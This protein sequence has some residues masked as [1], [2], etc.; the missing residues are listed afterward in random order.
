MCFDTPYNVLDYPWDHQITKQEL[1][2]ILSQFGVSQRTHNN[3]CVVVMYHKPR[4]TDIVMSAME[5]CQY[6]EFEHIFWYKTESH[7]APT[8]VKSYTNSVEMMTLGFFPAKNKCHWN[9][10]KDPRY[11]QN[12]LVAKSPDYVKER[13]GQVLNQSQKPRELMKEIVVNHVPMG[14][15]VLVVGAGAGGDVLGALNAQVNVVA[16]ENDEHQF[17]FLKTTLEKELQ[18]ASEETEVKAAETDEKK[19]ADPRTESESAVSIQQNKGAQTGTTTVAATKCFDCGSATAPTGDLRRECVQCDIK[20]PL[21]AECSIQL[22][23]S[24]D[25]LCHEHTPE[26]MRDTQE[27]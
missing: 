9:V 3:P 16:V 12:L 22:P 24:E 10:P 5:S 11:R 21:C 2:N 14:G 13:N 20:G 6:Q 8:P 27:E 23:G 19:G 18:L 4:D 25:W 7:A 15:H 26:D 17:N 1:V